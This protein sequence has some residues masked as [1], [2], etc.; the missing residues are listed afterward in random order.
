MCG[1]SGLL[2]LGTRSRVPCT[3]SVHSGVIGRVPDL[4]VLL[5]FTND[6]SWFGSQTDGSRIDG[7]E[8]GSVVGPTETERLDGRVGLARPGS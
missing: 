1:R 3:E 5:S 4:Y 6:Q 7:S 2:N 8:T